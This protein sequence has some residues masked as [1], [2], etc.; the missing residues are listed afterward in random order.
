MPRKKT[1]NQFLSEIYELV[2]DDYS[3]LE[4]YINAQ[5]KLKVRHN[6]CGH[7]YHVRPHSFISGNRC[8]KCKATETKNRLTKSHAE[9]VREVYNMSGLEFEVVGKYRGN[10]TKLE[11]KHNECGKIY[12]VLPNNFLRGSGCPHCYGNAKKPHDL[13]EKEFY[14]LH[15]DEYTLLSEYKNSYTKV[16]VK[17]NT[18]GSH[19]EV[20][21]GA[22]LRGNKCPNCN[23][24][25]LKTQEEFEGEV[26]SLV[27]KEY[28]VIGEYRGTGEKIEFKHNKCKN[29]YSTR[30]VAFLKGS[31]C[32]HCYQSKGES[33]VRGILEKNNVYF[34]SQYSF[35][36]CR[37]TLP[38]RFDF[39]ILN[40]DDTLN[41]LIE[42]DGIQHFQPQWGEENFKKQQ[43]HDK[44]KNDYCK[45]I[46]VKLL[47]IPYTEFTNLENIISVEVLSKEERLV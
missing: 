29:Y 31:R 9:F 35:P 1:N 44:I 2:G 46:G 3:F 7:E 26:F 17:H 21:S 38:L 4:D 11:V 43:K 32:P 15:G 45:K 47:R 10:K 13:Y 16:K 40:R 19:Y 24:H 30:A 12:E 23:L 8:P 42:Y 33:K 25:K 39:A 14:A 5:S 36:D 22:F 41:M 6:R 20:I 28:S 27:G 18:C 34:E 37:D